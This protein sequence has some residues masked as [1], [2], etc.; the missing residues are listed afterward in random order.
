[1]SKAIG[2]PTWAILSP[3]NLPDESERTTLLGSIVADFEHP[4]DN[5]IPDDIRTILPRNTQ[6][7]P[8]EDTN[9]KVALLRA[10]GREASTRLGDI[11]RTNFEKDV[12]NEIHLI[13]T[14]V[15]TYTLKQQLKVFTLLKKKFSKEILDMIDRAPSRTPNTIFMVVG[16]KSC[17]DAMISFQDAKQREIAIKSALP[18]TPILAKGIDI[19]PT[20]DTDLGAA[21]SS[22]KKDNANSGQVAKGARI[23]A[24]QYRLIKRESVWLQSVRPKRTEFDLGDHFVPGENAMFGDEEDGEEE[25]D[26]DIDDEDDEEDPIQLGDLQHTW[27]LKP[28]DDSGVIMAAL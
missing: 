24:L 26:S 19:P 5:Y 16:I 18:A 22:T 23:F 7:K 3:S 9:F 14:N 2:G 11:L 10:S 27:S 4:L 1:M 20:T 28:T 13:S 17:L 15:Q 12:R 8:T 6:G 21:A 25:D